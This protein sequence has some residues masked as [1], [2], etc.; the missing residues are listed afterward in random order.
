MQIWYRFQVL[1]LCCMLTLKKKREDKQQNKERKISDT[2]IQWVS[3]EYTICPIRKPCHSKLQRLQLWKALPE[4]PSAV[5]SSFR[6]RVKPYQPPQQGVSCHTL[7][8]NCH[9]VL[10]AGGTQ[11]ATMSSESS[12]D[13]VNPGSE[14][15][16]APVKLGS[17]KKEVL[18][19]WGCG[20]LRWQNQDS[21]V[22]RVTNRVNW[23]SPT[24]PQTTPPLVLLLALV[25]QI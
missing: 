6:S 11:A 20:V 21:F 9:P 5:M 10:Q 16:S 4:E 18:V 23:I 12:P 14:I 15:Y 2:K 17:S 1:H 22:S 3:T 25:L 8:A 19:V 24:P 7:C 13:L